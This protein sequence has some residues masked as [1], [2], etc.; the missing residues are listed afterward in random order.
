MNT[1]T[2]ILVGKLVSP[3]GLKGGIKLQSFMEN[4]TDIF[5]HP[6]TNKEGVEYVVIQTGNPVKKNVFYVS[7]QNITTREQADDLK[8]TELFMEKTQLASPEEK[9]SF[10]YDDLIGMNVVDLNKKPV[11]IIN[12][13]QNFGASDILEIK[14]TNGKKQLISFNDDAVKEINKQE[15][16]IDTEHLL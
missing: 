2:H 15:V 14:N 4:P 8:G 10:F 5:T 13:V 12:A 9:E 1:K 3:H 7:I 16:I 11:G 6:L